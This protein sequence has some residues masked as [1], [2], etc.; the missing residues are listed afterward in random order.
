MSPLQSWA[1][2]S[3]RAGQPAPWGA[4]SGPPGFASSPARPIPAPIGSNMHGMHLP[5]VSPIGGASLWAANSP[6]TNGD[7]WHP[8]G[9][10]PG[11]PFMNQASSAP[12]TGS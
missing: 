9:F 3:P 2:T 11:P 5:G 10:F 4:S 1:P 6:A 7:N 12:H 8:Q